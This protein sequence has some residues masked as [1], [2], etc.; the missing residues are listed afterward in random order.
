MHGKAKFHRVFGRKWPYTCWVFSGTLDI[1]CTSKSN[2]PLWRHQIIRIR[3]IQVKIQTSTP[4]LFPLVS[5]C[6][7]SD[8]SYHAL[9]TVRGWLKARSATDSLE[10]KPFGNAW[11]NLPL[12]QRRWGPGFSGVCGPSIGLAARR[13]KNHHWH[14]KRIFR[15]QKCWDLACVRHKEEGKQN[16]EILVM[17][18]H[19]LGG[20]VCRMG[21][22]PAKKFPQ[23]LDGFARWMMCF[24]LA[25]IFKLL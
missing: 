8:Q 10:T 7:N 6:R 12:G 9:G 2:N 4:T 20:L 16:G 23:S 14:S 15:Q 25:S 24:W 22:V 1:G 21:K 18:G 13:S 17:T 11:R 5:I 3:G 19:S